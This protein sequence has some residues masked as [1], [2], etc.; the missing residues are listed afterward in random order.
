M[1]K[2][3]L[4]SIVLLR[5][6]GGSVY[7]ANNKDKMK[8]VKR[9]RAQG[10]DIVLDDN[11]RKEMSDFLINNENVSVRDLKKLRLAGRASGAILEDLSK[12]YGATIG[13][14]QAKIK[15]EQEKRI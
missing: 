6:A 9:K 5:F 14:Y 10:Q 15:D 7:G 1:K 8:D 12:K 2:M 13:D 3:I 4:L 11:L